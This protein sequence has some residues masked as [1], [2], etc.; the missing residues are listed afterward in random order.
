MMP[1]LS[2][3]S[4]SMQKLPVNS[5]LG[6]VN[7]TCAASPMIS[8]LR[9][10]L[11]ISSPPS[12]FCTAAVAIVVRGHSTELRAESMDGTVSATAGAWTRIKT[13]TGAV[14]ARGGED[15]AIETVTGTV[16]Y[17]GD[18]F[19][20]VRIET[21][22]GDVWFE[23]TVVR[24]A[25]LEAESHSGRIELTLPGAVSAE[26]AL[27]NFRGRIENAFDSRSARPA[28]DLR[29]RTLEFVTGLGAA[30]ITVRN[31]RGD[32]IVRQQ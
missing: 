30:T 1:A 17:R 9:D 24:G 31:F 15:V 25:H 18:T 22:D 32:I 12:R 6:R 26:F 14:T 21:V 20:R 3:T 11:L 16:N 4:S 10:R 23:G 27:S 8:G 5:L 7:I 2:S 29:G 28:P 13:A 19:G